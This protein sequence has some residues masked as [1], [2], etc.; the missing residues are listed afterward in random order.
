MSFVTAYCHI[1]ENLCSLNGEVL[2][3]KNEETGE[4]WFKQIYKALA[5]EYPKFY[6]M[7]LISQA[8]F[9]GSELIKKVNPL[10]AY[11]D[12]EV[13]LLFGN[14]Q[15][16]ADTD[17]RFQ[18]SY[19]EKKTPSPSLF[20][21]TLPNIVLGE[22]AIRNKWYGENMFVVLPKFT[23][24]FFVRYSTILMQSGAEAVLGGWLSI[25]EGKVE[26]FM[27]LIEKAGENGKSL[28]ELLLTDYAG[29]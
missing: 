28:N 20:V 26:V 24:E 18:E 5:I 2:L 27:F 1:D 12:D 25:L 10:S 29:L 3:R 16:S 14:K 6:K 13:A 21:Y 19:L 7:D 8:G 22:I 9:L 11:A 23:P 15:S 17:I 4:T